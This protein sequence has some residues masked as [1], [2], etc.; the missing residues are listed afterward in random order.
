MTASVAAEIAQ[1]RLKYAADLKAKWRELFD[2][3]P[4]PYNR[5][6]L[7]SRIAYRIQELA[8]G[9]LSKSTVERLD[10]LAERMTRG[11]RRRSDPSV[12]RPP[13]GTRLIREWHGVEHVVTV[14]VAD[15]EYLGRPFRSLSA[16]ARA[17][18]G[19]PWNGLVFF[20]LKNAR[21]L[22]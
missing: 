16:V 1:L 2:T 3:A 5:K 10:D 20:G 13:V 18:T 14:R 22:K 8:F 19:T 7:Q 9:G 6:F 12:D 4:P 17:I 15:F 11:G 21:A